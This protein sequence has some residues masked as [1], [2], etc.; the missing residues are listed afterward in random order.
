[1]KYCRSDP[2]AG[3]DLQSVCGYVDFFATKQ[4]ANRCVVRNYLSNTND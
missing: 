2:A 1:M 3:G 4:S